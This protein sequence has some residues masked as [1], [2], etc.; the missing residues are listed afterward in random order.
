MI[1]R[2]CTIA[3]TIRAVMG[4]GKVSVTH[5]RTVVTITAIAL[6]ASGFIPAAGGRKMDPTRITRPTAKY[7]NL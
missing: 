7:T 3:G 4:M 5:H 2:A 6:T 1:R